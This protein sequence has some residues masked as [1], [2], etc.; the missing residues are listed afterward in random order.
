MLFPQ[1]TW[2][3]LSKSRIGYWF[4]GELCNA[5]IPCDIF[6]PLL[7]SVSWR[8]SVTACFCLDPFTCLKHPLYSFISYLLFQTL[9]KVT[10]SMMFS[11]FLLYFQQ[12]IPSF[13]IFLE[14]CLGV[15]AQCSTVF[16]KMSFEYS[17]LKWDFWSEII[18]ENVTCSIS[19]LDT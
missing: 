3:T 17:Y 7:I 5:K 4:G 13:E 15:V 12:V 6:Q 1:P 9:L 19:L 8:C 16:P 2:R 18:L 14:Y 11:N 10:F